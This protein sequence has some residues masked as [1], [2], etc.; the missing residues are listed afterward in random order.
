MVI[1]RMTPN[2]PVLVRQLPYI[3]KIIDDETWLESERR[4]YAVPRDDAVVREHVCG[5]ILRIGQELRE[6]AERS[7]S[8]N[9]LLWRRK[10]KLRWSQLSEAYSRETTEFLG[11]SV[12]QA[13]QSVG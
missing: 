12:T 10:E 5:V 1:P 7:A 3:K 4:G 11:E 13:R 9:D 2:D 6:T 8:G